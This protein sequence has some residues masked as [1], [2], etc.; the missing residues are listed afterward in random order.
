MRKIAKLEAELKRRGVI[1]S[2]F[3]SEK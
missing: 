3:S 1:E 2:E